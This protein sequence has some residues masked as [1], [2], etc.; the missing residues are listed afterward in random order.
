MVHRSAHVA[1]CRSAPHRGSPASC[2]WLP[3]RGAIGVAALDHPGQL[4]RR[5]EHR[6]FLGEPPYHIRDRRIVPRLARRA[7]VARRAHVDA[8]DAA[9]GTAAHSYHSPSVTLPLRTVMLTILSPR[10]NHHTLLSICSTCSQSSMH[11]S[12]MMVRFLTR[13]YRLPSP[14]GDCG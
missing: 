13:W 9:L 4:L 8:A 10:R 3:F 1:E 2:S 7:D 14:S 5:R 11:T 12:S 6:G